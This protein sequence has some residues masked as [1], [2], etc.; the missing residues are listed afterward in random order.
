MVDL[1]KMEKDIIYNYNYIYIFIKGELVLLK[2]IL[3]VNK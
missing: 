1:I 2:K 3:K